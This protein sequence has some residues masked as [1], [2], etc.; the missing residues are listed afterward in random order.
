MRSLNTFDDCVVILDGDKLW[1]SKPQ[2]PDL[3]VVCRSP[4]KNETIT[5]SSRS[6]SFMP[7]AEL[8]Q[9]KSFAVP[10]HKISNKCAKSFTRKWQ[11]DRYY[12]VLYSIVILIIGVSLVPLLHGKSI[13]VIAGLF[14]AF[15]FTEATL[16]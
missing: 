16:K 11:I 10:V 8:V 2:F 5:V 13:L 14:V 7:G 6:M 3:C 1:E 12:G 4:C 9:T 15:A